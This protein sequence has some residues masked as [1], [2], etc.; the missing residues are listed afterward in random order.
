[1]KKSSAGDSIILST[2]TSTE[3]SGLLDYLLPKFKEETGIE[4]KV[5]AVGTGKALQMGKDGG[6]RYTFS[7]C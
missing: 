2:T 3:D 5:I 6:G 7:S 4:V 1:M